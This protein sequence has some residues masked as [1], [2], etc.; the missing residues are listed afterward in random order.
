MSSY[1]VEIQMPRISF[2]EFAKLVGVS[3][4]AITY[5]VQNG[6]LNAHEDGEGRRFLVESEAMEDWIKN[7]NEQ[8]KENAASF[9]VEAKEEKMSEQMENGF[10]KL[11]ESRAIKEAFRARIEKIRYEEMLG[12]LVDIEKAQTEYFN[13][14]RKIRDS[15]MAIPDRISAELA[16]ETNQFT[17]NKKLT[18]ELKVALRELKEKV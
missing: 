13:I 17:V 8:Q 1:F 5:A 7:T 18:N 11:V 2:A 12:K 3:R 14:A 9:N 16:A 10:P 4:A 6:R 15:L